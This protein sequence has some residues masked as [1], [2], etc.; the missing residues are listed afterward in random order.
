MIGTYA[1][2]IISAACI[3]IET[4][5]LA[6]EITEVIFPHPSVGEIIKEVI[7]KF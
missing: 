1:S 3:M 4:Q 5:M 2:E 6:E 7:F